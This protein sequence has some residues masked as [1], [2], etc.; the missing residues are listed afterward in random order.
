M[1]DTMV[2]GKPKTYSGVKD[3]FAT[4]KCQT[5]NYLGA[6]SGTLMESASQAETYPQAIPM[7]QL[8][9]E[10]KKHRRKTH[11]RSMRSIILIL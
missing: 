1:I 6:L 5:F 10:K 3:E 11:L 9:E 7:A 2:L 8:A 4:W